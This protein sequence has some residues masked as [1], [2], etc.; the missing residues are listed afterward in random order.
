MT[1]QTTPDPPD[2]LTPD[3]AMTA[4]HNLHKALRVKGVTALPDTAKR[5]TCL[6]GAETVVV[7]LHGRWWSIEWSE[8]DIDPILPVGAEWRM[9]ERVRRVLVIRSVP[10]RQSTG[11]R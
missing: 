8:T 11:Q 10:R 1:A 7:A 2:L 6:L 9:A 4:L 5:C 3:S